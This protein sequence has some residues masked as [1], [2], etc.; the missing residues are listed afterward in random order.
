MTDPSHSEG[1][2]PPG[3]RE[4]SPIDDMYWPETNSPANL[5]QPPLQPGQHL[6]AV[7]AVPAYP[8]SSVVVPAPD[9]VP[10]NSVGPDTSVAP[11]P[12]DP[13]HD[14][15]L[16][17]PEPED[18]PL[19][20]PP[21]GAYVAYANDEQVTESLPVFATTL[22]TFA[23]FLTEPRVINHIRN[24]A[25]DATSFDNIITPIHNNIRTLVNQWNTIVDNDIRVRTNISGPSRVQP[26]AP[27]ALSRPAVPPSAPSP[28]LTPAPTRQVPPATAARRAMRV[29][30]VPTHHTIQTALPFAPVHT[31]PP[32]NSIATR[33]P[34]TFTQVVKNPSTSNVVLD[35]ARMLTAAMPDAPAATIFDMASRMAPT[36]PA[37][38]ATPKHAPRGASKVITVK[39][40]EGTNVNVSQIPNDQALLS[41]FALLYENAKMDERLPQD[42]PNV[43]FVR[44]MSNTLHI[45]FRTSP[46][47][48]TEM[49]VENFWNQCPGLN[50]AQL[51][52]SK[53][54]FRNGVLYRRVPFPYPSA[55]NSPASVEQIRQSLL[56]QPIACLRWHHS[57]WQPASSDR[58]RGRLYL[59]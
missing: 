24:L 11:G 43:L 39:P 1:G 40:A 42:A 27:T 37:N 25:G 14:V 6:Q 52:V 8:P 35:T 16:F 36:R 51:V 44:W 47:D 58:R 9:N 18:Q 59:Q 50:A 30:G 17:G 3:F 32:P 57:H 29:G 46:I 53:F 54:Q 45:Q 55:A 41:E 31:S 7:A 20:S 33:P 28:A 49:L 10:P 34:P 23:A 38:R 2:P 21:F 56:S 19:Y 22:S 13:D 5:P 12:Q 48:G 26:A 4:A 15:D